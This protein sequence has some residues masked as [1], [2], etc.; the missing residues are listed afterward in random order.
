MT[1]CYL[2]VPNYGLSSDSESKKYP[3]KNWRQLVIN[4]IVRQRPDI[5]GFVF[6]SRHIKVW[7]SKKQEEFTFPYSKW[8]YVED[9]TEH[10]D[11]YY[12]D[13]A[14]MIFSRAKLKGHN[15]RYVCNVITHY[16]FNM[17]GKVYSDE[18]RFHMKLSKIQRKFCKRLRKIDISKQDHGWEMQELR[19]AGLLA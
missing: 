1:Y 4:A 18:A 19:K 9:Q 8:I 2:C 15:P 16:L 3:V 10:F 6:H 5:S 17:M 11:S 13:C 12:L 14:Y 7:S